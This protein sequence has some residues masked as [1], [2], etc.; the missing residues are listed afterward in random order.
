MA[1]D[2]MN[3]NLN[4][5]SKSLIN[6]HVSNLLNKYNISREN[7]RLRELSNVE[8]NQLRETVNNLQQQT[9]TFLEDTRNKDGNVVVEPSPESL[10]NQLQ[11]IQ[12]KRKKD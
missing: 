3:N 9:E 6:M 11:Q 12:G 2:N 1:S 5:I 4:E 8:K 10:M 7:N